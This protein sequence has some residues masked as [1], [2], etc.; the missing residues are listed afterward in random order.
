MR[1]R[2]NIVLTAAVMA[3][4]AQAGLGADSARET[5]PVAVRSAPAPVAPVADVPSR[6][7]LMSIMDKVGFAKPL[8]DAGIQ[9]YGHVEG[10]YTYNFDDP[11]SSLSDYAL[12]VGKFIDNPGRVF[13]VEH[14]KVLMNQLD[15][16]IE[17]VVDVTKGQ[18]DIGGRVELL[19]GADAR[20]LHSN[21]MFDNYDDDVT[22]SITGGPQNQ[23]DI[24]QAYFD[25]A[26][27]V[28]NGLRIR[29][30]KFT[31]FKQHDPNASV[32]YSHSFTF[33]AALPF[34]LTGAFGT[35][36]INEQLS[37]DGGFSRGWDQS[38]D[39]N[40]DAIDVFGRARYAVNDDLLLT[41]AAIAGPEQDGDNDN[42]RVA[43]D[44]TVTYKL[45]DTTTLLAD[46]V[47]GWQANATG[48]GGDAYWYG[49]S[50]YAIQELNKSVSAAARLEWYR[51][52]GGYTTGLDQ[53][54]YEATVGLTIKPFPTDKYLQ[55]L[56]I[57]P[58]VRVDYS[59]ENYFDGFSR[60]VQ[61]TAAVDA[62]FNF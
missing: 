57:R 55:H 14:D 19:Y 62:V 27:P 40:N 48:G 51:D 21:G 45:G 25:L 1:I 35:Y 44:L 11:P 58:E 56:K 3:A 49:V 34:T 60:Q 5:A 41:F 26:V 50:L 8:E 52:E 18:F 22:T 61:F 6:R 16:N 43:A 17:R 23:F 37:V 15:L 4:M 59:D 47:Y 38:I 39:D 20:F 12:P 31:F 36:V 24:P 7:P 9:I 28:G 46:V 2:S 32:F 29:V 33:G 10:S 13:D 54:L 53:T 30:G 42:W